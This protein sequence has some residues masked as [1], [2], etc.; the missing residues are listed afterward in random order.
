ML[1]TK[2]NDTTHFHRTIH[3]NPNCQIHNRNTR[4]VTVVAL[5]VRAALKQYDQQ[6]NKSLDC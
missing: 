3:V 4:T 6:Y 5:T 1:A 2:A